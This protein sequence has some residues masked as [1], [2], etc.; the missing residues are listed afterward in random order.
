M[1]CKKKVHNVQENLDG[2]KKKEI[3]NA[4]KKRKK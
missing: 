2:E 3:K 1:K 4:D